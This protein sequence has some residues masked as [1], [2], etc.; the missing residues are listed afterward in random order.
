MYLANVL[1]LVLVSY[2][3][4]MPNVALLNPPLMIPSLIIMAR[5]NN[6]MDRLMAMTVPNAIVISLVCVNFLII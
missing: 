4:A 5:P 3:P 2:Y 1:G 6:I